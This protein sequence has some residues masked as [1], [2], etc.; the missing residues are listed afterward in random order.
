MYLIFGQ[1]FIW[2]CTQNTANTNEVP[3]RCKK[4]ICLLFELDPLL[5]MEDVMEGVIRSD[6]SSDADCDR[7]RHYGD[8]KMDLLADLLNM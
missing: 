8:P 5:V 3:I 6:E 4:K 7:L 1:A 2:C